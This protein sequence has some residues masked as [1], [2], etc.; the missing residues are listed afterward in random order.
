MDTMKLN[1]ETRKL[2]GKELGWLPGF[3][4]KQPVEFKVEL[5]DRR[6][7]TS[8]D[9]MYRSSRRLG[10]L[11]AIEGSVYLLDQQ[12]EILGEIGE[13]RMK[14]IPILNLNWDWMAYYETLEEALKRLGPVITARIRYVLEVPSDWVSPSLQVVRLHKVPKTHPD[15]QVWFERQ[16]QEMKNELLACLED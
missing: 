2:L 3:L 9:T 8:I 15:L 10:R 16:Q 1:E 7:L 13:P 5:I 6:S 12:G 14:K 11:I 4:P